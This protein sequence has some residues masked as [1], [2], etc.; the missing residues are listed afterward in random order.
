MCGYNSRRS[1]FLG[2]FVCVFLN[3]IFIHGFVIHKMQVILLSHSHSIPIV[4]LFVS[5]ILM[6]MA[7]SFKRHLARICWFRLWIFKNVESVF[8]MLLFYKKKTIKLIVSRKYATENRPSSDN[9]KAIRPLITL[10]LGIAVTIKKH[11]HWWIGWDL[12]VYFGHVL[13]V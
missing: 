12:G 1:L 6:W 9:L 5:S 13:A 4:L 10:K 2:T 7:F 8:T 3:M 11:G